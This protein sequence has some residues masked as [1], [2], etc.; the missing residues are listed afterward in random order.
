M[1]LD[2]QGLR[3]ERRLL[4]LMLVRHQAPARTLPAWWRE[5]YSSQSGTQ[6]VTFYRIQVE[7]RNGKNHRG[8]QP[9]QPCSGRP[10]AGG[11]GCGHGVS[12]CRD[13]CIAA[14]CGR[15][16]FCA[17]CEPTRAAPAA[18]VAGAMQTR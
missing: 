2:R 13:A 12:A 18:R 4:G 5:S 11:T 3:T 14:V 10:F 6:H 17:R 7:M 1:Q 9:A 15:G 8:R 16:P